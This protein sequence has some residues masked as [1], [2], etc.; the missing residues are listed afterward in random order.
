MTKMCK[1]L[2]AGV[3]KPTTCV[4]RLIFTFSYFYARVCSSPQWDLLQEIPT[5]QQQ[6]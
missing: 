4:V 1:R 5:I 3:G 2:G 6:M